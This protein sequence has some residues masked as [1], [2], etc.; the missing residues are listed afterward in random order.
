MC[1]L[2]HPPTNSPLFTTPHAD[3]IQSNW[4]SLLVPCSASFYTKK[5]ISQK[6]KRHLDPFCAHQ[7]GS[8]EKEKMNLVLEKPITTSSILTL[9]FGGGD[10]GLGLGSSP[11]VPVPGKLIPLHVCIHPYPNPNPAPDPELIQWSGSKDRD[12]VSPSSNPNLW[13]PAK[14]KRGR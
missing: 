4:S 14:S 1:L 5:Q 11:M 9:W 10:A 7:W 3:S 13:I 6:Q 12:T 2:Y 8:T